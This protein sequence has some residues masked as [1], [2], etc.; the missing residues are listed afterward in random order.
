MRKDLILVVACAIFQKDE[1][2]LLAQR[3][4]NKFQADFWEFPGGKIECRETPEVALAR[5]LFEELSIIVEPISLIPLT[6]VSHAY[7]EF[8]LLMP[9]FACYDFEGHLKGYEGQEIRWVKLS[10]LNKYSMLPADKPL[11]TFLQNHFLNRCSKN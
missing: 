11:V 8:H 9:F 2:V 7:K 3:P 10:D 6:F 5:E 1:Q 4:K